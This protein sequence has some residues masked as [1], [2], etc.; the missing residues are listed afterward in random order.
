MKQRTTKTAR[1]AAEPREVYA[2][3]DRRVVVYRNG[4]CDF[5]TF[6]DGEPEFFARRQNEAEHAGGMWLAEQVEQIRRAA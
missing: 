3:P 2:S 6:C 4:P 5:T 1:T